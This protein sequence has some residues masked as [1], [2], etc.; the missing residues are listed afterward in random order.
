MDIFDIISYA[1]G[2]VLCRMLASFT[3]DTWSNCLKAYMDRFKYKNATSK[4]LLQVCDEIAGQRH[5]ITASQ[6]LT[7]W[8]TQP[9]YPI[10]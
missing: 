6:F 10:L 9:G 4:D 8:L 1:K 7:P 2:S 5:P 3:G